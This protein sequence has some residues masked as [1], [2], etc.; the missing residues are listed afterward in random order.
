MPLLRVHFLPAFV[1]PAEVA[2][3]RAVVI[4]VLRA[5][6]T[7]VHALAAGAGAVVPCLEIADA[8]RAASSFSP[9]EVVLGG[10]RGGLAIEGFHLGNSPSEYTAD[11]VAGKTV[12]LTT[13]NG[14]RALLHASQA[15]E[16]LIGALVN[17]SA[18]C[19]RLEQGGASDVDILCAGTDA[20]ITSDDVLAA[21]AMA[22]RLDRGDWR[23]DDAAR[24]ARD[25]WRT[26]AAS[27][28]GDELGARLTQALRESRGGRNLVRIGM[29]ADIATAAH[30]DRFAVVPRFDIQSGRIEI[31]A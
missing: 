5:T 4:D 20:Q 25:A 16:I 14:T 1:E 11:N 18:V 15:S 9:H 2:G 6:T 3:R 26:V 7:I 31:A 28:A 23:F 19:A 21:G 8:R 30:L 17:L 29:A 13:T 10:E 12:I 22:D 24:I 27:A